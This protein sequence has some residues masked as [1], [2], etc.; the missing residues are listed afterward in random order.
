[1]IDIDAQELLKKQLP[2]WVEEHTWD[3]VDMMMERE[4]LTRNISDEDY[5]LLV[6]QIRN[7]RVIIKWGR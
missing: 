2:L 6:E 3:V 1:M 5:D 7:A 4:Y